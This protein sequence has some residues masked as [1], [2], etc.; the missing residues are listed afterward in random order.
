[1]M[2]PKT[3]TITGISEWLF[4]SGYLDVRIQPLVLH[5]FVNGSN[6]VIFGPKNQFDGTQQLR[7]KKTSHKCCE[8]HLIH[9]RKVISE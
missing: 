5:P 8:L 1:M 6:V 2:Q 4:E 7:E 9:K 3:A